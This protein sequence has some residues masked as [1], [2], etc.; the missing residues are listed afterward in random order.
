MRPVA[1]SVNVM[2]KAMVGG[3]ED[4][5]ELGER[6]VV[7]RRWRGRLEEAREEVAVGTRPQVAVASAVGSVSAGVCEWRSSS[8]GPRPN[9]NAH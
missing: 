9:K 5:R 8:I 2:V 4:T 7:W 1:A 6:V 3:M